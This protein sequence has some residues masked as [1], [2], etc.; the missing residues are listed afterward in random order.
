MKSLNSRRFSAHSDNP[1]LR[2]ARNYIIRNYIIR[3]YIITVLVVITGATFILPAYAQ[4]SYG[5]LPDFTLKDSENTPF[6]KKDLRGKVWIAHTFFTSCPSVCPTTITDIKNLIS[7]LP[8]GRRPSVMSITV[9]P[10]TD[11][12]ERLT[13]YGHKRGLQDLDW[14]LITGDLSEIISF[15]ENGL[16]LAGPGGDPDAHSPRIVLIDKRSQIRG[17]YLATNPLDL[18]RLKEE[19][20]NLS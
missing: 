7:G 19:L 2:L 12:T 8:D 17:Y 10:K 13:E 9:D 11:S 18:K 3:N 4:N 5:T 6:Q 14:K 1:F 20:M 16:R 15:I